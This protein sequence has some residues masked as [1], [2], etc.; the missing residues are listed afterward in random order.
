MVFTMVT[1]IFLPMSFMAA[2]FAIPLQNFNNSLQFGYVAKYMFGIGLGISVLLIA[3]AF[4][5]NQLGS[6]ARRGRL[7]FERHWH[8]TPKGP[9][10]NVTRIYS[11]DMRGQEEYALGRRSH[12]VRKSFE[13]RSFDM[14]S[15]RRRR[16]SGAV[17]VSPRLRERSQ[18]LERG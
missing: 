17:S 6:L 3:I 18:D 16:F 15:H 2:V 9:F 10:P 11:N 14:S 1:I 13:S 5:A 4:S 8:T 7:A 12:D